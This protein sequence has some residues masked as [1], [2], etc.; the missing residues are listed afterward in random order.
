MTYTR[1]KKKHVFYITVNGY[2]KIIFSLRV[3]AL[4]NMPK[5]IFSKINKN[6]EIRRINNLLFGLRKKRKKQVL[7]IILKL[8][9][10]FCRF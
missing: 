10:F 1:N 4:K 6:L 5:T 8:F 9:L 2:I 3:I 7:Q